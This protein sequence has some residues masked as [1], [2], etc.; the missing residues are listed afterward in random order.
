MTAGVL[1]DRAEVLGALA[2]AGHEAED[3]LTLPVRH[4]SHQRRSR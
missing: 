2:L 4:M 1:G 3:P